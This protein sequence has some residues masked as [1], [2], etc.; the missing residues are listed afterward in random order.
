MGIY[1]QRFYLPEE[2]AEDKEGRREAGVPEEVTFAIRGELAQMLL[3]RAFEAGVPAAWVAGD[4]T[5]G[6]DRRL[7]HWLKAD[8]FS[9][10]NPFV[11]PSR[12]FAERTK[13]AW[14]GRCGDQGRFSL[15][16]RRRWAGS[17]RRTLR[18]R[19]WCGADK[20]RIS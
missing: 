8:H 3:E 17:A 5:Y 1:R 18:R 19:G 10:R 14:Q 16:A 2:W 9:H 7:R 6:T 15:L 13:G 12:F 20:P 4:E 11:S